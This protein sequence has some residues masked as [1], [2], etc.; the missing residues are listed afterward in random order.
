M[1]NTE[2]MAPTSL[3]DLIKVMGTVDGADARFIAGGTNFIPYMRSAWISPDI[4]IDLSNVGELDHIREE[5]GKI[6]IGAMTTIT[7]LVESEL[8]HDLCPVISSAGRHLGNPLVRNRATIG[9]NLANASPGADMAPP[10]LA[11]DAVVHTNGPNN[12]QREIPVG[13]FFKGKM[14]TALEKDELL[15]HV[16]IPKPKDPATMSQIKLGLRN[17]GAISLMNI[18]VK[19][20]LDGKICR[21]ARIGMC[22]VAVTPIR[23]YRTEEMLEGKEINDVLLTECSTVLRE[24]L[25][26]RKHSVRASVEYRKQVATVLFKRAMHRALRG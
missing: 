4:I 8:I 5:N 21:K 1:D 2:F 20:D 14:E 23:A 22:P 12:K 13:S 17:S 15:T 7:D 11:L 18:A 10:L 19:L 26:Q 3:D 9:G 25:S 24:E 6:M 16:T